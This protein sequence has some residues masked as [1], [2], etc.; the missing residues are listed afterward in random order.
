MTVPDWLQRYQG[1]GGLESRNALVRATTPATDA[2]DGRVIRG[3]GSVYGQP[4]TIEGFFDEWDEEVAP[5]AWTKT[6][7][8][9]KRIVSTF[10]HEPNLLLGSTDAGTLKLS[11]DKNG[12]I[13][14]IDV[15]DTSVGN[16][17]W[18]LVDRG[19]VHGSS[20]WFRVTRQE[21][22]YKTKQNG[23]ERDKRTILEAQLFEVGPVVFPA[24]DT[25]TAD[26]ASAQMAA[27]D[28][29]MRAAGAPDKVRARLA[30]DAVTDPERFEAELRQLL[31]RRPDMRAAVCSCSP[32]DDGATLSAGHAAPSAPGSDTPPK[33]HL[34]IAQRRARLLAMRIGL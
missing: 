10:N 22:Q 14:E 6:I 19:D 16:D 11:E 33:R 28:A 3:Y 17:V 24:F 2:T 4:T 23:L 25:T 9:S 18:T 32:A 26:T 1:P 31:D 13:Y 15:P 30:V 8:E 12:L 29:A 27:V 7:A 21:W 34:S 5:G 20:V